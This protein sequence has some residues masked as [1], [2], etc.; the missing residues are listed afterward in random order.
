MAFYIISSLTP[1]TLKG[2]MQLFETKRFNRSNTVE[3][4]GCG[5]YMC[6]SNSSKI[7]LWNNV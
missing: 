5:A 2:R 6:L 3:L 7:Y 1:A 4:L